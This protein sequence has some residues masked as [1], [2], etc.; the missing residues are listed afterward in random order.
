[1]P[2]KIISLEVENIKR[3]SAAYVAADGQPI[4]TIGGRN[5]QGK[6]SL[7]D[8]IAMALGGKR[9]CPQEPLQRGQTSGHVTVD[10][11]AYLVTRRFWRR[12]VFA[13]GL[14]HTHTLDCPVTF[15]DLDSSLV[16]KSPDGADYKSPQALLDKLVSDLTFDP[17]HFL[18]LQPKDQREHV[19]RLVGL[20]FTALDTERR[21]ALT[22]QSE[23]TGVLRMAERDVEQAE[24][25]P[26][27]PAE[28]VDVAALLAELEAADRI[29]QAAREADAVVVSM[30]RDAERLTARVTEC[31]HAVIAAREALSKAER[32][33]AEAQTQ[34]QQLVA[35]GRAAVAA[36]DAVQVPDVTALRARLAGATE[37]NQRVMANRRYV[38][39]LQALEEA[40]ASVKA[41]KDAITAIDA[42]KQQQLE[43]AAFPVPGLAFSDDGLTFEGLPFEQASYAQQLRIAVAM[44]LAANPKLKVLLIKHGNA[45]DVKSMALLSDLAESAGAQV[46]LERVAESAD[47]VSVFLEAGQ[48]VA[49]PETAVA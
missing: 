18:D 40:R 33:L 36:A 45:L 14:D 2:V 48:V 46:W 9:L 32:A 22:R 34:R 5:G 8:A 35:D 19:R 1:V 6:S 4:V 26:Q 44:G 29:A 12:E 3:I 47:G 37:I 24:Q 43:G 38:A 41:A 27:A 13:C 10:L 17:L 39:I 30:R 28:P 15:G 21:V 49:A 31:S 7:L 16:V 42:Q 23:A 11:G 25:F 20:D